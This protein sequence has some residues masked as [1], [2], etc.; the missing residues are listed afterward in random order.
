M[1][2]KMEGKLHKYVS[3]SRSCVWHQLSMEVFFWQEKTSVL[4]Q[5]SLPA[6]ENET[7]ENMMF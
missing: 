3:S 5:K 6:A 7:V 2:F 4:K 1:G